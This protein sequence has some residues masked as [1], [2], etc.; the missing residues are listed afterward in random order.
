MAAVMVVSVPVYAGR[1]PDL[2]FIEMAA[3][4][5]QADSNERLVQTSKYALVM[6]G[7]VVADTEIYHS[8]ESMTFLILSGQLSHSILVRVR[9]GMVETVAAN[10]ISSGT[11][12]SI[13]LFA[14]PIRRP[15]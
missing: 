9:T 12:G 3:E 6:E 13:T 7:S 1:N 4:I 8:E 15:I 2:K 11:D 14:G 10:M 5:A